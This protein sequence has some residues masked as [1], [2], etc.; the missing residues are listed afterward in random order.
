VI[1]GGGLRPN[2]VLP[3]PLGYVSHACKS[4]SPCPWALRRAHRESGRL[5]S[6]VP[7]PRLAGSRSTPSKAGDRRRRRQASSSASGSAHQ[8]RP[9]SSLY[10][11][12]HTGGGGRR[13]AA[14]CQGILYSIEPAERS[15]HGIKQLLVPLAL[16]TVPIHRVRCRRAALLVRPGAAFHEG[17]VSLGLARWQSQGAGTGGARRVRQCRSDYSRRAVVWPYP[18]AQALRARCRR[19]NDLG[20]RAVAAAKRFIAEQ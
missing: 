13:R 7:M 20:A 4:H 11:R 19:H 14:E 10:A 15:T 17:P 6:L 12:A 1:A 8:R 3:Q 16:E 9:R 18:G 2:G 5:S